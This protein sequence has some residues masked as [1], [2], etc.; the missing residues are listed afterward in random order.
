MSHRTT[1]LS[2]IFLII[3][4]IFLLFSYLQSKETPY[5]IFFIVIFLTTV[6]LGIRIKLNKND[7]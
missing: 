6:I 7:N 4:S 1:V 2:E 3:A 5:L